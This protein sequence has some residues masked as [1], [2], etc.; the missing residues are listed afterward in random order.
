MTKGKKIFFILLIT[1]L[2]LLSFAAILT[3]A[4]F[5]APTGEV[6]LPLVLRSEA[7]PEGS[8]E[9]PAPEVKAKKETIIPGTP[10]FLRIPSINVNAK[11]Q[12]V[13]ITYKG[14]MATPNNYTDVG[15]FKY[16]TLPGE[17]GNAVIAGHVDNG[18]ALPGVFAHLN[19][20]KVGDEVLV[21]TFGG[22]TKRFRV[23]SLDTYDWNG[24]SEEI[25]V[26]IN[27]RELKLITCTGTWLSTYHTHDKR[28]VVTAL[29]I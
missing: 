14:N 29:A 10:K 8:T 2:A 1:I 9:T 16:G 11:V 25:F 23:T 5:Y 4:L 20:V 6:P 26:G 19:E 28:L 3:R 15:W 21:D 13:G 27:E 24:N 18:L 12:R 22:D 7:T 17:R